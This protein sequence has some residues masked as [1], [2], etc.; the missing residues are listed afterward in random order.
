MGD[1]QDELLAC[2]V[3]RY[4]SLKDGM[5]QDRKIVFAKAQEYFFPLF[6]VKF[7]MARWK[8]RTA[9][10]TKENVCKTLL[11]RQRAQTIWSPDECEALRVWAESHEGDPNNELFWQA[12]TEEISSLHWRTA[13]G[14]VRQWNLLHEPHPEPEHQEEKEE[15]EDIDSGDDFEE[16]VSDID[17]TNPLYIHPCAAFILTEDKKELQSQKAILGMLKDYLKPNAPPVPPMPDL[18]KCADAIQMP[19]NEVSRRFSAWRRLYCKDQPKI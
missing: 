12:A 10:L 3:E 8:S 15:K 14:M 17:Y 7:L 18:Q 4:A 13:A 5:I 16:D 11:R 6:D 19:L 2:A 9:R 1:K